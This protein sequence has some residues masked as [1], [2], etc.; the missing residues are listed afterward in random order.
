MES[1]PSS[2]GFLFFCPMESPSSQR[3][4]RIRRRYKL[5]GF[6]RLIRVQN[7]LMIGFCQILVAAFLLESDFANNTL[8]WIKLSILALATMTSAAGG[9]IINDYYDV[10]IDVLNKPRRVVV[11]RLISRRMSIILHGSLTT[12]AIASGLYLGERIGALVAFSSFWLWLYS[13]QLKRLPLIGNASIAMLT[14]VAIFLPSFLFP[15]ATPELRMYC[16]FAFWISLIRE[17]VKDMED[18]KGD[19]RHGCQTLPIALGMAKAK[20]V[21]YIVAILFLLSFGLG[22]YWLRSTSIWLALILCLPTFLF[23][24]ELHKA[25]TKK[26]FARLSSAC[27]WMMLIGMISMMLT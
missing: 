7:L 24:K 18:I 17:I 1:P 16:I 3:F 6:L 2:V 10:K 8:H 5:L 9:Y 22:S 26:Q 12:L 15:P 14:S 20:T 27:K 21:I 19:A 13:N 25:D 11:G 4:Q 23:F